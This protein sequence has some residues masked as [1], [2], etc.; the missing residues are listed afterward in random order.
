[1]L[2]STPVVRARELKDVAAITRL[3]GTLGRTDAAI[4]PPVSLSSSLEWARFRDCRVAIQRYA[5]T[6]V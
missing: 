2:V 4:P 5:D 3:F 6:R 1:M